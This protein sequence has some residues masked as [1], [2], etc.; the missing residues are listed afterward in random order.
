M[1]SVVCCLLYDVGCYVC[2]CVVLCCLLFVAVAVAEPWTPVHSECFEKWS[3]GPL[4]MANVSRNGALD[5]M[6]IANVS[7]NGA[8]GPC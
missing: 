3:L 7:R 8:S 2:L 6:F 1:L 5:P 4:F